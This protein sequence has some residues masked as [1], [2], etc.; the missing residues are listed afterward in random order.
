MQQAAEML[1]RVET[2]FHFTNHLCC[3]RR[4]NC[5]HGTYDGARVGA[6]N[7]KLPVLGGIAFI[8]SIQAN[9]AHP[10]REGGGY[11]P[12]AVL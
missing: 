3:S 8:L 10:R 2:L 4:Y 9:T 6:G 5:S 7:Q 12:P 1:Q 11:P